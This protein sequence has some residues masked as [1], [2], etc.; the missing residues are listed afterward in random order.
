MA[1]GVKIAEQS[2]TIKRCVKIA[3]QSTTIKRCVKI[4]EQS[5]T[6]K[7]CVKIAEQSTTIK[8]YLMKQ[9]I[10]AVVFDM[11]GLM[12]NTEDLYDQV[13]DAILLKRGQ[14]FTNEVKLAMMGLPGD[15]AVSYTHLTLPTTPYV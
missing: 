14:R 8:R 9:T 2:T 6:I 3:E 1:L 15:K 5:T 4:A 11:D 10:D 13:G 12:F 7:G